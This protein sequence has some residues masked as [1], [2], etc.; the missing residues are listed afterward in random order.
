MAIV[1]YARVSSKSQSLDIQI[2]KLKA[3]G[4]T[5]VYQEKLSGVDQNRPE[6]IRCK[7]YLRD[8]YTLV[9]TKLD[10]MARSAID[11]GN[12]IK[13]FEQDN[14][15]LVVLDQHIDTT[16]SYGK[17]TFQILASVAEFE[18]EIRKERQM[19]G[20]QKAKAKGKQFG[21]PV[22]IE[23]DTKIKVLDAVLSSSK[24]A[25]EIGVQFKISRA[26]VF[27]IKKEYKEILSYCLK[28]NLKKV[29]VSLINQEVFEYQ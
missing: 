9:I 19:E 4:C 24:S 2:D 7:E 27:N 14:I 3:Y 1:G 26:A 17:L 29:D 6:L 20:I 18:N 22:K 5:R 21:R 15:N 10:R 16:T 28:N 13:K 11:L 23:L 8:G 25:A 12:I